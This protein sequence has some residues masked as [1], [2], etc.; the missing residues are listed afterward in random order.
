MQDRPLKSEHGININDEQII[1]SAPVDGIGLI[2]VFHQIQ[3]S[4]EVTVVRR[5]VDSVAAL[6]INGL[7][8]AP[9]RDQ[10]LHK[11]FMT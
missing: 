2:S 3:C 9:L 7:Q 4:L 10:V 11:V 5:I 1:K 6:A 8:V